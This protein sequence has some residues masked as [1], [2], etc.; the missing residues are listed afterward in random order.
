MTQQITA[1]IT[2]EIP[3]DKVLIDKVKLEELESQSVQGHWITM[4]EFQKLS[5]RSYNWLRGHLLD[6][7]NFIKEHS[8]ENGGWVAFTSGEG[9]GR[10]LFKESAA[11]EFLEN[12]YWK[13]L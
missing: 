5:G 10:W 9:G 11:R 3:P 2:L 1:Q 7:P 12:E 8:A 6:K 4:K 13:Y